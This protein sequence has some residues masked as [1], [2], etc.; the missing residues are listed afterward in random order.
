MPVRESPTADDPLRTVS[1]ACCVCG[2]DAADVIGQGQDFEYGTSPDTFRAVRCRTCGLVYLNPRPHEAEFPRIYPPTYHAFDFS[3]A[4]FGLVF[5]VRRWLEARRLLRYAK[6]LPADARVLDVGC[7]DGFHLRLLR[8]Y[9]PSGWTLEGV[10]ASDRAAAAAKASGLTVH[11]GRLEDLALPA[12]SY[13]L[14]LLIQTIEHLADPRGTLKAIRRVLKS[15]SVLVVVTDN[16]RSLDFLLF[17]RRHWG[18]YHFPRHWTLFDRDTLAKLADRAGLT[19]DRVRTIVSPVNWVYS[20][21]NWLQDAGAPRFVYDRFS[22]KSPVALAVFTLVDRLLQPFG[23][24]ALLC[25]RLRIAQRAD[26]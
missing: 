5:R 22:L 3:P 10:D 6:G 16:V 15:S 24:G 23:R 2:S 21:R 9:G 7:G 8:D 4:R 1:A 25:A 12:A 19:V 13:D 11:Q 18:G 20:F 14:V 17:R 26:R